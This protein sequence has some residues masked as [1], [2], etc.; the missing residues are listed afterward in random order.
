MLITRH[1][2]V[3][4]EKSFGMASMQLHVPN[5]KH[6][7]FHIASVTKM[8]IAAAILKY[9]EQGLLKLHDH[10]GQYVDELKEIDSGITIHH[11]LSHTSGL[12]DIYAVP[13][14]RFEIS[15]LKLENG[16]FLPYLAGL[17]QLYKPGVK[18][19]YSSTGYIMMGYILEKISGLTFE[20]TL[21][22]LFFQ[23]LGMKHT[24]V[25]NPIKIN[26]GR[27]Y[28]HTL[29]DGVYIH[30]DH[31]KLAAVDAPGELYSTVGDLNL[32]CDSLLDGKVLSQQS[33]KSMLTP[34]AVTDFDPSLRYGYGWFI[35]SG[36]RL[37]GGGTHGFKSEIWQFP[38]QRLNVI[39]LWNYEK[40]NSHNLFRAIRHLIVK[41]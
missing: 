2:K 35:G 23:P 18:W 30:A 8:F 40:A 20:E 1:N 22:R 32:W 38:E 34:Y 16:L 14:V 10:P 21:S 31:D 6:T 33:M 27:A 28:G 15:R 4:Y 13:H 19:H 26:P 12:S 3:L 25:D 29:E 9:N 37:I 41:F 11:L 7:K 36:F 17:K 39:M 24:G 5:T